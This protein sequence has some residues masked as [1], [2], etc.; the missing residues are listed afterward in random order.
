MRWHRIAA[1]NGVADVPRLGFEVAEH[2]ASPNAT[3]IVLNKRE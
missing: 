3:H 2:V 1:P